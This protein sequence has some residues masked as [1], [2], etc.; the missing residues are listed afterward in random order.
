MRRATL[1]AGADAFILKSA[2]VTDLLL[3]VDRLRAE[4]EVAATESPVARAP[5][6]DGSEERE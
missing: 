1:E 2:I 4:A 5:A 6:E 3:A